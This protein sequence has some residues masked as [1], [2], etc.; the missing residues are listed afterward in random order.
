MPHGSGMSDTTLCNARI[1][2]ALL[3]SDISYASVMA[4]EQHNHGLLRNKILPLPKACKNLS[5]E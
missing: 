2:Y 1:K 5:L 3:I 4:Q